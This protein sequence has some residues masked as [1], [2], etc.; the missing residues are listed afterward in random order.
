MTSFMGVG[1]T[2]RLRPVQPPRQR[3]L[4]AC[5]GEISSNNS[6]QSRSLL[7]HE[8]VFYDQRWQRQHL[9]SCR[10][11]LPSPAAAVK[12]HPPPATLQRLP[13]QTPLFQRVRGCLSAWE[14]VGASSGALAILQHGYRL[15]WAREPPRPFHHGVSFRR[16]R[17]PEQ[18]FMAQHIPQ[19]VASGAWEDAVSSRYVSKAF[20]VPKRDSPGNF[21]VVVDLQHVNSFL[22]KL[23]VR[24]ESLR[25]LCTMAEA[26]DWMFSFDLKDGF[27]A[28]A[29]HP[30][31]RQYLTIQIEGVGYLQMAALPFGLHSSPAVFTKIMRPFIQ[32]LRA[33][34][35]AT[36]PP[37]VSTPRRPRR[38]SQ[39][40]LHHH[41]PSCR[42]PSSSPPLQ[43]RPSPALSFARSSSSRTIRSLLPR[44]GDVM[45]RGLRCLPYMD[46]FLVLSRGGK[47]LSL[48]ER[49]YVTAVLDLLGLVRNATKGV[50]EPCQSLEHLGIGVDSKRGIFFVTERRLKKLT[51]AGQTILGVAARNRSLV[52][53]KQLAAFTGLAQSLYLAVPPARHFLRSLHNCVA[54]GGQDWS[55]RVRLSSAAK[56]DL[57][58]F[59]DLPARWNGRAIRRSPHTAVLH[60]DASLTAWGAVLNCR[61]PAR[62][63]WRPH[64]RREHITLLEA[65]ALRYGVES[66]V[67]CLRGRRVLLFGDNQALVHTLSSWT[68]RSPALYLQLRKL[69]YLLDVN[70]ISIDP[71]HLLSHQ[72]YQADDLTR[73]Y[74]FDDWSIS[75]SLFSALE[76]RWGPHS[77]DRFASANAALLPRYNSRFL[78]PRS[79]GVDAFA[80]TDWRRHNN[81]CNPPIAE[82]NRLAQLLRETGAAATVLAPYW[83]AQPW[84]QALSELARATLFVP[85]APA[86]FCPGRLGRSASAAQLTWSVIAFRIEASCPSDRACRL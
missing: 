85:P 9:R 56:T 41:H 86:L 58:F 80:Q 17:P 42:H 63:F 39:L 11:S 76:A 15:Q 49:D 67:R 77:V 79:S 74:P 13:P 52:P 83:P 69:W 45:R 18:A 2:G 32:A 26:D 78:D 30:D 66:F 28:V 57:Q 33:P 54:T 4:H 47:A 25:R 38:C 53:R 1:P 31:C 64:Q 36:T 84:F 82:L 14:S 72:N 8:N 24:F 81:Y 12:R 23:S 10:R 46:D 21:R 73:L 48:L 61:T 22:W 62:G 59:I 5:S 27:H 6:S 43:R 50:W 7:Q 68:S 35:A 20:L 55:R 70:D 37:V 75:G 51:S 19:M 40:H 71:R 65:R 44:F 29:I 60:T 3:A 34:L 16:L